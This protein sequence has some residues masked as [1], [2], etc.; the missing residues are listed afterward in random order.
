[1]YV[2]YSND[3][4]FQPANPDGTAAG[5]EEIVKR[6]APVPEYVAPYL[7]NALVSAGMIVRR[8]GRPVREAQAERF[9]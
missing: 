6:G 9:P 3:L 2:V 5:D 4:A 7:I 1:M 8:P